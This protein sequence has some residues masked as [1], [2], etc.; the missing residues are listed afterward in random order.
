MKTSVTSTS[1]GGGRSSRSNA[2][3]PSL[4]T[5]TPSVGRSS[6]SES[7]R[8]AAEYI[9]ATSAL[10]STR[11][12]RTDGSGPARR[13]D[14]ARDLGEPLAVLGAIVRHPDGDAA[15]A[16]SSA[17]AR[18]RTTSTCSSTGSSSCGNDTTS[19]TR[20]PSANSRSVRMNRPLSDR[21][22]V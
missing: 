8:S 22:S 11:S 12:T 1:T 16:T 3:A 6:D 19:V 14:L 5:S 20:S 7:R 10:S 21:F 2:A 4:A 13:A 18:L 15:R 17:A 9:D